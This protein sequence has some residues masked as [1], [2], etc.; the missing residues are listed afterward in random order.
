MAERKTTWKKR[1]GAFIPRFV[2]N[3]IL[4]SVWG[5]LGVLKGT[6]GKR[7]AENRSHN[8]TLL[9]EQAET[10]GIRSFFTPGTFIENQRHW[11]E[12]KFGGKYTMSYGGCEIFA[13]YNALLS[14]GEEMTGQRL[15]ELI[16]FFERRGA[17]W[18]GSLGVAPGAAWKYFKKQKYG[19]SFTWSRKESVIQ[20]LGESSDTIIVTA[21]NDGR[22]IFQ[23]IHTV[24]IS[25]D[26]AGKYYAHN[27][28]YSRRNAKGEQEFVSHGPYETLWEAITHLSG[29]TAA[30]ICVIG[31]CKKGSDA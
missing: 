21:Y 20:K 13:V 10:P 14:L 24:N 8:H 29:G 5:L 30:P 16:S 23:C 25:K 4:A 17:V 15:V 27:D 11:K 1:L 26:A 9:V 2:P 22:D 28:F 3:I 12:V 7:V 31:I 6:S 19:V 18:A